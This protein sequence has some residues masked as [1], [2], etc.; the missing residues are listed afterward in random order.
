M[1]MFNLEDRFRGCLLGLAVGDALGAPVEGW[2][3]AAIKERYGRLTEMADGRTTDD[4]ALA[5]CIARSITD[6]RGWDLDDIGN[7]FLERY[8]DDR[9]SMGP[10]TA[11]TLAQVDKGF[12]FKDAARAAH[13]AL[14]GSATNG[15]AMRSAPIALGRLRR[16]DLLTEDTLA[17]SKLTHWDESAGWAA[18]ALN[19]AIVESMT[20]TAKADLIPEVSRGLED[21]TVKEYVGR[22]EV[23]DADDLSPTLHAPASVQAALWCYLN[24]DSFEESVITAVNLGGD[25]DT[26][27]AMTGAISGAAYGGAA[28][29]ERW[30]EKLDRR[31][32]IV[33]VCRML[34]WLAIEG[35]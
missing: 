17:C 19:L 5:L 26:I 31:A 22:V 28:I 25:T 1:A 21:R 33:G 32:E 34:S 11:H 15:A 27:A 12:S 4:T 13:E 10:T 35:Y 20:G 16:M 30:L 14:G 9:R 18:V 2:T 23:M 6:L 29:P 8:R 24:T 3:S 7:R